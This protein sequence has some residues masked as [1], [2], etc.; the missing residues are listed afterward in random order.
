[1]AWILVRSER[2]E[3]F[4]PMEL[5][6]NMD[7]DDIDRIWTERL[8]SGEFGD[9]TGHVHMETGAE[10]PDKDLAWMLMPCIAC[11]REDLLRRQA[12]Y[13]NAPGIVRFFRSRPA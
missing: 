12:E 1:M 5:S 10:L 11:D 2:G 7:S 3:M 9:P 8:N 13:D 4:P 6:S